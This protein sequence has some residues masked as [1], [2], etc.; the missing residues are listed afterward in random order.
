MKAIVLDTAI[1][2]ITVGAENDG[3]RVSQIINIGMKQSET[4]L[5]S[6]SK[7]MEESGLTPEESEYL[8]ISRGPGSFTGLRLGYA[9]IKAFQIK[10]DLPLYAFST[11][12]VY[13]EPYKNL[14]FP[15]VSCIDAHK[16]RFYLKAFEN[17][18]EIIPEGDYDEKEYSKLLR[19]AF[20]GKNLYLAGPDGTALKE[21]LIENGFEKENI[22]ILPFMLNPAD[23]LLSLLEKALKEGKSPEND[24]DGPEYLR[25]SDAEAL[26]NSKN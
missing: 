26:N 12:D 21:K 17:G 13:A 7:V 14:P 3:K 25:A 20:A 19:E 1:T 22:I 4:L 5:P 16:E 24:Y 10:K 9:C 6:L 8:C 23:A 18:K 11:L 2:Q 15:L